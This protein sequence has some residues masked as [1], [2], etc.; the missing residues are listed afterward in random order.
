MILIAQGI[1]EQYSGEFLARSNR[2]FCQLDVHLTLVLEQDFLWV[3]LDPYN[4]VLSMLD[5]R[6]NFHSFMFVIGQHLEVSVERPHLQEI[7]NSESP[8]MGEIA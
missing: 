4:R 5:G 6:N 8:M 1:V 3:E 7:A 2:V